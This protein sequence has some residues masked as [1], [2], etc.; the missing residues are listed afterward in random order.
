MNQRVDQ[1]MAACVR[2]KELAIDHVRNPGERMP[3]GRV[4][5]GERPGESRERNTAIHHWIFLDICGVIE[6]D[7]P[8]PD[9]LRVNPKRH[10]RKSEQ[11]DEIGSLQCCSVA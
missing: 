9:Y 8:M 6:R 4:K 11:D 2:A 3:I 1:Q 7:E 5:G 10:Y